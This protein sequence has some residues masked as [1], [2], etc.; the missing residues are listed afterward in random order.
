MSEDIE[1]VFGKDYIKT[2]KEELTPENITGMIKEAEGSEELSREYVL[3]LDVSFVESRL[4][5]IKTLL[6]NIN[7]AGVLNE[8]LTKVSFRRVIAAIIERILEIPDEL[9]SQDIPDDLFD[10]NDDDFIAPTSLGDDID[11]DG[12]IDFDELVVE[13]VGKNSFYINKTLLLEKLNKKGKTMDELREIDDE[14]NE[15]FD[16]G[17]LRRLLTGI[18]VGYKYDKEIFNIILYRIKEIEKL[19]ENKLMRVARM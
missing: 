13:E 10:G 7:S 5:A 17:Y 8:M 11:S 3:R 16:I 19:A 18:R 6:Q 1:K 2:E 15:I 4:P 14:I 9:T 12:N